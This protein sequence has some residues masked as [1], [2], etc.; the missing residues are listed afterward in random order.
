MINAVAKDGIAGVLAALQRRIA[1]LRSS[2]V[3]P[4]EAAAPTG[5]AGE[6]A[7]HRPAPLKVSLPGARFSCECR[8]SRES[9]RETPGRRWT[10]TMQATGASTFTCSVG[11]PFRETVPLLRKALKQGGIS[12]SAEIDRSAR[13]RGAFGT[14]M[15][16]CCILCVECPLTMLPAAV[17]DAP[18]IGLFPLHLV[19]ASTSKS[20]V[21]SNV[22]LATSADMG[23]SDGLELDYQRFLSRV[24][25]IIVRV[26]GT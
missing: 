8:R 19:V 23:L 2:G 3:L 18:A 21:E 17:T 5:Q 24:W 20:A 11:R 4:D 15:R 7:K 16:P 26:A 22:Y 10:L 13:G 25:S 6:T 9:G 12:V 1:G 14:E